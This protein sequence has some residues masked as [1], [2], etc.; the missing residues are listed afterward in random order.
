MEFHV[1]LVNERIEVSVADFYSD[2]YISGV[3]LE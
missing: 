2:V 1:S 3:S